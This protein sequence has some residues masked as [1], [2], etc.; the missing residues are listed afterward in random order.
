[1]SDFK[2]PT[3]YILLNGRP[4]EIGAKIRCRMGWQHPKDGIKWRKWEDYTVQE[5]IKRTKTYHNKPLGVIEFKT[6]RCWIDIKIDKLI[7]DRVANTARIKDDCYYLEID[8]LRI[9]TL[10]SEI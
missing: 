5:I 8:D 6:S 1:M 4:I 10:P 7:E 3:I 9:Y 2:K